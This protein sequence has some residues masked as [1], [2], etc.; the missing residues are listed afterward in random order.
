[1]PFIDQIRYAYNATTPC[2][3]TSILTKIQEAA[4]SG[5]PEFEQPNWPD[6]GLDHAD[7]ELLRAKGFDV[8]PWDDCGE[9]YVYITG[10]DKRDAEGQVIDLH[11]IYRE[12][13]KREWKRAEVE[14]HMM[15]Y[16]CLD[17]AMSGHRNVSFLMPS[18]N[19]GAQYKPTAFSERLLEI[20]ETEG[21]TVT[22]HWE[23]GRGSISGWSDPVTP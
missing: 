5:R 17:A 19:I 9:P 3:I 8:R 20:L 18:Y 1:V 12:G 7:I 6:G 10:W 11:R 23:T 14:A 22:P 21:L 16:A 4:R 13:V 2:A 15:L